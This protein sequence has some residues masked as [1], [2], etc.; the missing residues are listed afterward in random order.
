MIKRRRISGRERKNGDEGNG[1]ISKNE[2]EEKREPIP[3]RCEALNKPISL[4]SLVCS[5]ESIARM[6]PTT[7]DSENSMVRGSKKRG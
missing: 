3:Q 6:T 5:V 2:R 4:P 7:V 1:S